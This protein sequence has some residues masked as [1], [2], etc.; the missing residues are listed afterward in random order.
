MDKDKEKELAKAAKDLKLGAKISRDMRR[1]QE[2][3]SVIEE[4]NSLDKAIAKMVEEMEKNPEQFQISEKLKNEI[5]KSIDDSNPEMLSD[6]T[7]PLVKAF[8]EQQGHE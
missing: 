7:A 1:F 6:E 5:A 2:K 3:E 4:Q 8:E